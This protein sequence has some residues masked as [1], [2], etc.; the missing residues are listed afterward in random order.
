MNKQEIL[1]ANNLINIIFFSLFAFL[2]I[3]L[4]AILRFET[5]DIVLISTFIAV[6]FPKNIKFI[7]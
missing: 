4:M 6:L 2:S 3:T 7:Q 5:T 1:K